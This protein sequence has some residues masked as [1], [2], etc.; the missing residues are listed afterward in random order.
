MM[1]DIGMSSST[2]ISVS[3]CRLDESEATVL[4]VG[5]P[6][7]LAINRTEPKTNE[8]WVYVMAKRGVPSKLGIPLRVTTAPMKNL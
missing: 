2:A 4:S 3:I 7:L 8:V 1:S 6:Q 5:L